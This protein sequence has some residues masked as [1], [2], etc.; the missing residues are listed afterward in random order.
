MAMLASCLVGYSTNSLS[1]LASHPNSFCFIAHLRSFALESHVGI[2]T[3]FCSLAFNLGVGTSNCLISVQ[4]PQIVSS[5]CGH[6]K[7]YFSKLN[8]ELLPNLAFVTLT[9]YDNI[10]TVER[11]REWETGG[12]SDQET[13]AKRQKK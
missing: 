7:S 2:V 11:G 3:A 1:C 6:F 10:I 5:R 4:A 9:C 13:L 12:Q 8:K